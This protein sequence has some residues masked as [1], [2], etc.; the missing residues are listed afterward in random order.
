MSALDWTYLEFTERPLSDS[1][2]SV[3]TGPDGRVYIA[4][5]CEFTGGQ[6]ATLVRY[7]EEADR[8]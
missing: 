4:C 5:C 8:L 6:S 2:W 7:D 1:C 3:Q